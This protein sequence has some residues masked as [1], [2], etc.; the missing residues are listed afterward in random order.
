[1]LLGSTGMVT[2]YSLV[3]LMDVGC[4]RCVNIPLGNGSEE[5]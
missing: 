2:G 3:V 5:M 1:M 4:M